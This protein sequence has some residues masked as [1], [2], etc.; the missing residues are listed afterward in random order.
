MMLGTLRERAGAR[1]TPIAMMETR[2]DKLLAAV[3]ASL[4]LGAC[5][6]MQWERNG[7]ALDTGGTDWSDCRQ[8]SFGYANRWGFGMYPHSYF[9]RDRYGRGFTY[10]RPSPYPDR[11]LLE[12][13]YLNSCLRA[14]GFRM[15]PV[16]SETSAPPAPAILP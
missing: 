13:D 10:Y 4:L 2:A 9:A 12:Q 1:G 6:P 5:A 7:Q 11:F 16:P 15:V 3:L 8:Q 14:R